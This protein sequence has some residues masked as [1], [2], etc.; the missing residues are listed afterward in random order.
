LEVWIMTPDLVTTIFPLKTG[1]QY[2]Q[3]PFH[4]IEAG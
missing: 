1:L 4:Y 3:V 2:T